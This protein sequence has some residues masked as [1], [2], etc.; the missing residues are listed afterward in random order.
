MKDNSIK[1]KGKGLSG[2][3]IIFLVICCTVVVC[4]TVV[5]AIYL[6]RPAPDVFVA[7]EMPVVYD[8]RG[9]RV[10]TA[11]NLVEITDAARESVERGMFAT[12][13]TTTWTFANG[14]SASLDA[15]K[16][17][18]PDNNYP[19]WFTVTEQSSGEVVFTSGLIPL[20]AR[21]SDITLDVPLPAGEYNAV[22]GVNMVDEDGEVVDS[23]VG[24]G[25]RLVV[26]N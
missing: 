26:L 25:I 20:G 21:L 9:A 18:A 11:E 8:Q 1:P 10:A 13:M 23:N 12:Y 24:L 6:T 3:Q 7:P 17:N 19:F 15:L 4:V 22:V 16:G 14:H 5:A 2:N